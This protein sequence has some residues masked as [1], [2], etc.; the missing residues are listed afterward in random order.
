MVSVIFYLH[1]HQPYRVRRY[2]IFD[3]CKG[4]YYWDIK[5]NKEI[6][7][8]V[9][10]KS[11][12]PTTN[13]LI[14]LMKKYEK[15]KVSFSITGTVLE[16]LMENKY[17]NVIDNLRKIVDMGGEV[18][19]ETYYH[20]LSFLYSEEEFKEQVKMHNEIINDVFGYDPKIF[21]NTEL[22][23]SN[24]IGKMVEK[25]GYKGILAE[26]HEKILKN[27]SPAFIYKGKDINLKI[28]LRNYRLSDDIAFR[29]SLY[30]WEE[31]PLTAD[32]FAQWVSA[33]N[34]N[35]EVVNLFMDFET[36]GEHQWHETGILEFLKHVPKE[37]LKHKDNEFITPSEAIRKYK[38]KEEVDVPF[39][40]SW[41]DTE[42]DL[43]AWLGNDM[44]K[45]AL[46]SV[47]A[48]EKDVKESNNKY[49][50]E[51]WRKLQISD[52]FYFMCTKWFADGDVHKYFNPYETPYDAF[53]NY[54]NILE[55]LRERVKKEKVNERDAA[56]K[57]LS[58]VPLGK[59]FY[60]VN[61]KIA[62]NIKE[63]MIEIKNLSRNE[64]KH[65]VNRNKND[66]YNWIKDVVGDDELS[67]KIKKIRSKA[68]I[69]R[70]INKRIKDLK[71]K[72]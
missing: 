32:K 33:Y 60:F 68:Q 19:D 47:Y 31:F 15:F 14:D 53:I 10:R 27:K 43:S 21:R 26:G 57:I 2:R 24:E 66:F 42:R 13:I 7:D 17:N 41:A 52:H 67:I 50:I 22:V 69:I 62:K 16:Q 5:K 49:L 1:I 54:M 63:L 29:F 18:V 51:E 70:E 64:F 20:S 4:K 36:F 61:G 59:E 3:I 72:I 71:E 23:Y 46:H 35:G 58:D 38:A 39:I 55:D 28:L 37:I 30:T 40:S 25:M 11:Y 12:L 9:V 6:L 65:H 48:L 44:Q 45:Y 56:L 8:R 34:G